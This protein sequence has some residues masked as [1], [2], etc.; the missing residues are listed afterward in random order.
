MYLI[1]FFM[2]SQTSKLLMIWELC[3]ARRGWR[4]DDLDRGGSRSGR[5]RRRRG[6]V[7]FAGEVNDSGDAS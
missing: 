6:E 1:V 3:S 4:G 7:V 5:R 2:I